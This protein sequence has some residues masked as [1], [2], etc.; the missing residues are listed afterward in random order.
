VIAALLSDLAE[1]RRYYA[2]LP[3]PPSSFGIALDS[4]R[5][6]VLGDGCSAHYREPGRELRRAP[7]RPLSERRLW[8]LADRPGHGLRVYLVASVEVLDLAAERV[9][10]LALGTG[11]AVRSVDVSLRERVGWVLSPAEHDRWER[12]LRAGD[13]RPARAA[14]LERGTAALAAAAAE[15]TSP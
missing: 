5:T 7:P 10:P 3:G 13:S 4:A 14:M 9:A 2:A 12:A 15:W 6:G 8:S 11:R 1:V